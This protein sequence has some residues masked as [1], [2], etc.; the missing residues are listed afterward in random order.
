MM[1]KHWTDAHIIEEGDEYVGYDEAGLE[2][3]RDTDRD[4]VKQLL[5]N[6]GEQLDRSVNDNRIERLEAIRHELFHLANS[7]A[8]DETGHVAVQLHE[9]VNY[10]NRAVRGLDGDQTLDVQPH[11]IMRALGFNS[12]ER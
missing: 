7:Y 8:G 12:Q 1:A 6:H 2:Y 5:I 9:S 4:I 11:M 3:C 10:I